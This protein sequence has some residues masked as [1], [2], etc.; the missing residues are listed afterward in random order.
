MEKS[1]SFSQNTRIT[2]AQTSTV[3][4]DQTAF[5]TDMHHHLVEDDA[6]YSVEK[7]GLGSYG[8]HEGWIKAEE[9]ESAA[10]HPVADDIRHE[11]IAVSAYYLAEKR[12][13]EGNDTFD[14]WMSAEAEIDIKL[15]R[16][17]YH[18]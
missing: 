18:Y 16:G 15:H 5:N 13:F 2:R 6:H 1:G 8:S 3:K 17:K 12:G 11:M 9:G 14:D 7:L 10:R 4:A